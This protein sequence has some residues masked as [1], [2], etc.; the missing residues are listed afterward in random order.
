M[1]YTINMM[2]NTFQPKFSISYRNQS[3]NLQ[4]KSHDWFLYE[5]QHWAK[6]G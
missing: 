3:F 2:I 6:L 1:T 5:M 4:N